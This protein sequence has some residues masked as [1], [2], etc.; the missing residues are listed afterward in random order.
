VTTQSQVGISLVDQ[1]LGSLLGAA[2]V[3]TSTPESLVY[4]P[5]DGFEPLAVDVFFRKRERNRLVLD[6]IEPTIEKG[7]RTQL[8]GSSRSASAAAD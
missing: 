8:H 7:R 5:F 3:F 6:F 4:C 1:G 2:Y